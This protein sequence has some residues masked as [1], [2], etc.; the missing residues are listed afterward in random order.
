MLIPILKDDP[1]LDELMNIAD[2]KELFEAS[3]DI[4]KFIESAS[5]DFSRKI[6]SKLYDIIE[7]STS[8][9]HE[10]EL[11]I[12]AI[13]SYAVDYKEWY[14]YTIRVTENILEKIAFRIAELFRENGFCVSGRITS[15]DHKRARIEIKGWSEE[16][17]REDEE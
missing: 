8:K 12:S 11:H 15:N 4:Q 9:S 7:T 3:S 6:S 13:E 5:Q 10:F 14:N 2:A 1:E 17:D 16:L